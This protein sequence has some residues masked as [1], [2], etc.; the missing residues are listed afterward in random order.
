MSV[1]Y[2]ILLIAGYVLAHASYSV[3]DLE[4]GELLIPFV[5]VQSEKGQEVIRFEADT[6]EEAISNGKVE[7][8]QLQKRADIYGFAR[9]GSMRDESGN[10]IDVI[11][12]DV[13][14]K[15]LEHTVSIVQ[16]FQP[17]NGKGHFQLSKD[18]LV[19]ID[20]Q[21]VES[22]QLIDIVKEGISYHPIGNEFNSWVK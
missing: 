4:S 18:I 6:Q 9:E 16:P 20:G 19:V 8:L 11:S 15:G 22:Q 12:V 1:S 3:S 17:N 10:S 21:E 13:W 5:V 2:S 7:L 14:E